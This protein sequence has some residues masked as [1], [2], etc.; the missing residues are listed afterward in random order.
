MLAKCFDK[1]FLETVLKLECSKF[2]SEGIK[3][4]ILKLFA[5]HLEALD[6]ELEREEMELDLIFL[7]SLFNEEESKEEEVSLKM[8]IPSSVFI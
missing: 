7:E 5:L 6:P 4:K 1:I 2:Y 8:A 3:L